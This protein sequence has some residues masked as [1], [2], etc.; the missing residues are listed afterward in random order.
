MR[1]KITK[2]IAVL[3]LLIGLIHI[4]IFFRTGAQ[5][6][7]FFP[8]KFA[9][10]DVMSFLCLLLILFSGYNI[11]KLHR[12]GRIAGLIVLIPNLIILTPITLLLPIYIVVSK[13]TNWVTD[14]IVYQFPGASIGLKDFTISNSWIALLLLFI[15]TSMLWLVTIF[16]SLKKTRELFR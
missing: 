11:L 13:I 4:S 5:P 16:L 12:Y 15:Y 6:I 9:G 3:F 8:I 10:F 14:P 7:Y 2:V 1:I